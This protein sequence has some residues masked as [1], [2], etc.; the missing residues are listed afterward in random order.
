[1]TEGVHSRGDYRSNLRDFFRDASSLYDREANS[2]DSWRVDRWRKEWRGL[3]IFLRA[4]NR[5]SRNFILWKWNT[6]IIRYHVMW[7]FINLSSIFLKYFLFNSSLNEEEI[8]QT[9][10]F[11]DMD[12]CERLDHWF[13]MKRYYKNWQISRDMGPLGISCFFTS[14]AVVRFVADKSL[15]R[16]RTICEASPQDRWNNNMSRERVAVKIER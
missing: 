8:K 12:K 1:M 11:Y 9:T 14:S 6:L 5:F 13:A 4:D 3:R 10:F 2:I 7:Q 15:E 16:S